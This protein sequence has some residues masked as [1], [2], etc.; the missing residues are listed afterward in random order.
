MRSAISSATT[1]CAQDSMNTVPTQKV[2]YLGYTHEM[3]L[4]VLAE[5][6]EKPFHATQIMKWIHHRKVNDFSAMTDISKKLREHLIE[7]GELVEPE[8][9]EEFVSKDGTRKW[10]LRSA[11][12]SL[13]EM[14]FIPEDS[15]G[16][17]CVSSQVGCKL[18]CSFCSTGKQ[19]YNSD[20][21]AAEIV[22][23]LRIAQRRLADV[24]PDRSRTVTN[25]VMMG[26]GEPLLNFESVLPAVTLMMDDL[27]Y[28]ISKRKVTVSTAGVVPGIEKLREM[29]DVSLAIS[30]HAPN[31]ELR[32]Q[33]V[34][35]N[36]KYPIEM[37]LD[38]CKRYAGNLGQKRTVTVEYTLIHGVN[39]QPEHALQ[40]SH[41]LRDFPCKI[42]LIPFNPFPGT[43][44]ERPSMGAVRGFQDRLVRDGYS[45]T[46]RTTRGDDIQAACGQLVGQVADK[47]R[48]QARYQR[49]QAGEVA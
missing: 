47:T 13:V 34:P 22:G 5:L 7:V 40:L 24:Y 10:L 32:N 11:S 18:D 49:I 12:G 28:G 9:H 41:L 38:A 46:V 4:D 36:R 42:N 14:V 8:V 30:L 33:L 2:N 44:Y 15:R 3:W 29:T 21:T 25:V 45:V 31:D 20:L 35:I 19:G 17:L 6:G 26:M 1:S 39:D 37:L 23:Q 27:G 48:R 16:T 43:D